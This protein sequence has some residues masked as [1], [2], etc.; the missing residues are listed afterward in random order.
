MSLFRNFRPGACRAL[1]G[2]IP[3][4]FAELLEAEIGGLGKVCCGRV[5]QR[6]LPCAAPEA[7]AR[8]P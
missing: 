8:Y 3:F 1:P 2:K 6:G 4:S 5:V 7:R